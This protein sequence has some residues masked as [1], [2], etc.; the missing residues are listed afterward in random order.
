LP[1]PLL[2][3]KESGATQLIMVGSHKVML[4][5]TGSQVLVWFLSFSTF[6]N[7]L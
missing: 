2:T 3:E 5:G 4:F 1:S 6:N 7:Q